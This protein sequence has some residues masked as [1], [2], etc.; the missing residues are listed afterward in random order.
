MR[1][2]FAS[3]SCILLTEMGS[4]PCELWASLSSTLE[5]MLLSFHFKYQR[6]ALLCHYL[7]IP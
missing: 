5:S 1:V 7:I 3:H 6:S 2:V 4:G